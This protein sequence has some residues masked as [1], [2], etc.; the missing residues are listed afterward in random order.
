M[1]EEQNEKGIAL[2]TAHQPPVYDPPTGMTMIELASTFAKSGLFKEKDFSKT[3]VKLMIGNSIGIPPIVAMTQIHVFE[4][5]GNVAVQLG[6][7]ILGAKIKES[8]KYDYRVLA[9]TD[10]VCKILFL[11]T[12][13]G[14]TLGE[15]EYT[16][17]EAVKAGL[18]GKANWKNSPKNMLFARAMSTGQRALCP[19]IFSNAPGLTVY[20]EADDIS[21]G[22]VIEGD[23]VETPKPTEPVI[24]PALSRAGSR[25]Q[26]RAVD[27]A[28]EP[29]P[30]PVEATEAEAVIDVPVIEEAPAE[31]GEDI[32]EAAS[33]HIKNLAGKMPG[34]IEEANEEHARRWS[35]EYGKFLDDYG[36]TTISNATATIGD[37]MIHQLQRQLTEAGV[38]FDPFQNQ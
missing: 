30:E 34:W 27:P 32:S 31:T 18:T 36:V 16:W 8:G 10:Q 24:S 37:R 33:K 13:N 2:R 5:G 14:H 19:D 35:P 17:Q 23:S 7:Q 3:L 21:R 28:P 1:A 22:E 25:R 4:A 15:V 26:P 20:T 38:A 12:R 6:Y 11:D 29:T 9:W